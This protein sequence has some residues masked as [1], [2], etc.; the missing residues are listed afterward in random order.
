MTH[1]WDH[2]SKCKRVILEERFTIFPR[3]KLILFY[4]AYYRIVVIRK[5]LTII[6][7]E[8]WLLISLVILYCNSCEVITSAI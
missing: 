2:S 8:D 7:E 6:Q 3:G 1:R 5:L 4:N